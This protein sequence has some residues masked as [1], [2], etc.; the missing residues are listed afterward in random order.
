M[1]ASKDTMFIIK[2]LF[3]SLQV[4]LIQKSPELRVDI[5]RL[6]HWGWMKYVCVNKRTIIGSDSGLSPD[7]RQAITWPMMEYC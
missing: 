3:V 2:H 7:R 1:K 6:T 4:S 5:L